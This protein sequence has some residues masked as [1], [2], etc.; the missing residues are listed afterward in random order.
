MDEKSR[1]D[2]ARLDE[3][4]PRKAWLILVVTYFASICA[5]IAQFKIPPMA[6]WL[7]ANFAPV[8]LDGATF[9]LLMSGMAIIGFVLAFPAAFICRK[10]GL[11]NTVLFSLACLAA[12]SA[13][14]A[15]ADNIALL[16]VSRMIEGIGIGLIG[17]AAPTCVSVWFPPR[18]R[19]LALGIWATWVPFGCVFMFNL[20]P[21]MAGG[22]P[23]ANMAGYQTVFWFCAAMSVIAFVLFAAVFKLPEGES[24]DMGI[25]GTFTA[26]LSYL[27]N[28]HIWYLGIVFFMFCACTLSIINT[29]YQQFL[30]AGDPYGLSMSDQLAG[31]ITSIMMFGAFVFAPVAGAVSDKLLPNSKRWVAVVSGIA[32]LISVFFGFV[33]G[34]L[35]M[36][37]LVIFVIIQAIAGAFVGGGCR[38]M[39]PMIMGGTAMGATMGMAVLQFCMNLG[40]AVTAPVYGSLLDAFGGNFFVPSMILQIPMLIVGIF[41]SVLIKPFEENAGKGAPKQ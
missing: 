28:K 40:Q 16:L 11:K 37:A 13:I 15:L 23:G 31:S 14:S 20:A 41:F 4:T 35:A 10:M 22:D 34:D 7:F 27:K 17:V 32:L 5:P 19:G 25:E 21:A 8:G 1:A 26:S 29:Y 18:R 12:G 6:N 30:T 38:P 36:P 2:S 39:A 33:T 3:K 24:G 9:G